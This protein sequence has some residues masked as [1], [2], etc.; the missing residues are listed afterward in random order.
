MSV[1]TTLALRRGVAGKLLPAISRW[2]CQANIQ[3]TV[4]G[5]A[6]ALDVLVFFP[7]ARKGRSSDGTTDTACGASHIRYAVA[8]G[9]VTHP[10]FIFGN[11]RLESIGFFAIHVVWMGCVWWENRPGL[12]EHTH[13]H[14]HTHTQM[15]TQ[16]STYCGPKLHAG[17]DN[18]H[19]SYQRIRSGR[20]QDQ[21]ANSCDLPPF[22][23]FF[24]RT[25]R[26]DYLVVQNRGTSHITHKQCRRLTHT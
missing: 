4:W 6:L 14:T 13:T 1:T 12:K 16:V 7:N 8:C 21:T 25:N 18:C 24:C 5:R 22:F 10:T 3:V 11:G 2:T 23:H 9:V 19:C 26:F 15:H 20:S 17:T